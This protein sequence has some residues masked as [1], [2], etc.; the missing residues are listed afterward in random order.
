MG[1]AQSIFRC[2]ASIPTKKCNPL[3]SLTFASHSVSFPPS[4]QQNVSMVSVPRGPVALSIYKETFNLPRMNL[5]GMV[6]NN[7][8]LPISGVGFYFIFIFNKIFCNIASWTLPTLLLQR[9]GTRSNSNYLDCN[10]SC[11]RCSNRVW[12]AVTSRGLCPAEMATYT[13]YSIQYI[14]SVHCSSND[15]TFWSQ[16][17]CCSGCHCPMSIDWSCL[18]LHH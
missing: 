16:K 18:F 5:S 7:F 13:L 3:V 15:Q 12:P 9:H 6:H 17:L 8:Q 1:Q 14:A 10:L 11:P 2:L 4:S